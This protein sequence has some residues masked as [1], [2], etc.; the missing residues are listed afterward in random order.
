MAKKKTRN[1]TQKS[2]VGFRVDS[3][4][5]KVEASYEAAQT[6]RRAM[7]MWASAGVA[8]PNTE[9]AAAH[10]MLVQR[11]RWEVQN[12]PSA[13][14]ARSVVGTWTVGTGIVPSIPVPELAELWERWITV[15]DA[16]ENAVDFYGL[17]LQ[18]MNE[19]FTGGEV[20]GRIRRRLSTD[21]LPVPLQVQL[22][23]TEYMPIADWARPG[24]AKTI[25]GME[26]DGIGRRTAYW[27]Y[28]RHPRE[29]MAASAR[30]EMRRVP[31]EDV[32]HSYVADDT[33]LSRG[34]PWLSRALITL[35]DIIE[36]LDAEM[37]RKK[38]AA[39]LSVII[40]DPAPTPSAVVVDGS[41]P[42]G[43]QIEEE[44]N[45]NVPPLAPGSM[46]RVAHGTEVKIV[47]P[48]DVGGQF[49]PF[50][51]QQ[52]L[53]ISQGIGIPYIL[54]TG[55]FE[56]LSDRTAHLALKAF[57]RDVV[58][59]QRQIIADLCRPVWRAWL[60]AAIS[61]GAWK[62]KDDEELRAVQNVRWIAPPFPAVHPVQAVQANILAVA[63]GFKSRK[64]VVAE[65]GGNFQTTIREIAED[66]ALYNEHGISLSFDPRA[67]L[68]A[69]IADEP[70]SD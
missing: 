42:N 38:T 14:R 55:D 59:W 62:P 29:L 9:L 58:R 53:L 31:A 65:L 26:Y 18:A 30:P 17:Q 60:H 45:T 5:R 3:R 10:Y 49:S 2:E 63:A 57:E 23:P 33:G 28:D 64:Q 50:V 25:C 27:M 16:D 34:V 37:V 54:L 36:Y 24:D 52:F 66:Q 48:A 22:I 4:G 11:S 39:L 20:L 69:P 70:S 13:Y 1:V 32:I 68:E 44:I 61:T 43:G 21:G 47:Q 35:H 41:D 12:N 7:D 8:G 67:I 40:A 46:I 51:R 15:A 56:G 6:T 19:I